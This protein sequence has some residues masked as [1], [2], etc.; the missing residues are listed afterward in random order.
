M[1]EPHSTTPPK[2]V[3]DPASPASAPSFAAYPPDHVLRGIADRMD[4][5]M[6]MFNVRGEV[7]MANRAVRELFGVTGEDAAGLGR[8]LEEL[9]PPSAVSLPF[10]IIFFVMVDG[11][12]LISESLVQ[13]FA[14]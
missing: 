5:G 11:W 8:R 4:D 13:G 3:A 12:R 1:V 2:P 10:K 7:A 9:L 6:L 14:N